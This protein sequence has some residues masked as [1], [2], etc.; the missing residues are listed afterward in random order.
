MLKHAQ[1][2][3]HMHRQTMQCQRKT[4]SLIDRLGSDQERLA[5]SEQQGRPEQQGG[6]S[7]KA[8]RA[9]RRPEQQGGQSNKAARATRRP[10]QQGGQSNKAARATRRP[11]QQGGQSKGGGSEF[12]KLFK[13]KKYHGNI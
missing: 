4:S 2:H 1:A 9:T 8:A 11:E 3:A 7:N 12:L 10:E 13:T 5:G 6:Q